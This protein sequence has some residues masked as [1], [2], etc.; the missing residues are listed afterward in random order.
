MEGNIRW[1]NLLRNLLVP[2]DTDVYGGY[3]YS[4]MRARF[5]VT[6]WLSCRT[7]GFLVSSLTPS[8]AVGGTQSHQVHLQ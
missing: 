6:H 1:R 2:G 7:Q 5:N 4:V 8:E 3:V